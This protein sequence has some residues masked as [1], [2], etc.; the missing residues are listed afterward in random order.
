MQD[1]QPVG[2]YLKVFAALVGLTALTLG[3]AYVDFGVWNVVITLV[4]AGA[5]ATLVLLF[6]MHLRHSSRL[7]YVFAGTGFAWL[8]FLLVTVVS[9][10][11]TQSWDR[12]ANLNGWITSRPSHYLKPEPSIPPA[13][14]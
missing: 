9:D 4:I 3:T 5:K 10:F 8:V 7:V 12:P 13:G 1:V 2:L 11:V 14:R 6:F